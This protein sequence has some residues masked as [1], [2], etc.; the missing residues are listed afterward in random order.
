MN[1]SLAGGIVM[2][3]SEVDRFADDLNANWAFRAD[4]EKYEANAN[5]DK[6]PL[7]RAVAF[8]ARKGY[9]FT[10]DEA[11]EYVKAKGEELGLSVTD[12]DLDLVRGF[13]YAGGILGII[14]GDF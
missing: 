8:A 2:S 4:A 13:P 10:I 14:T 7:A 11:K 3:I 1:V 6:T 5:Q 9:S 12:A